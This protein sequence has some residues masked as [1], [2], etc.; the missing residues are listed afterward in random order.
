MA[1]V[2]MSEVRLSLTGDTVGGLREATCVVT[3]RETA[4]HLDEEVFYPPLVL[5]VPATLAEVETESEAARVVEA[6]AAAKAHGGESTAL[7]YGDVA[8]ADFVLRWFFSSSW[9]GF[10]KAKRERARKRDRAE[11]DICEERWRDWPPEKINHHHECK[12]AAIVVWE[13]RG[14]SEKAGDKFD[15]LAKRVGGYRKKYLEKRL[16]ARPRA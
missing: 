14:Y 5:Q 6:I 3:L 12:D 10:N 13:R 2:A 16:A 11:R 4:R 8:W 15:Q 1:M 9:R 7:G